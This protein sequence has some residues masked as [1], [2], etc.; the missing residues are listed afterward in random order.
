M[1]ALTEDFPPPPF[2]GF[3]PDAL[4]FFRELSAN[5]DK[6]WFVA[7]KAR[8]E[9]AVRAPLLALVGSLSQGLA[10]AGLPFRGDPKR[11]VFRLNRDV[12]FSHDKSPYKTTAGCVLTR[13][14]DKLSPGVLYFHLDPLGCFAAAGFYA[15]EPDTLHR[16]RLGILEDPKGW[17]KAISALAKTGLELSR[18]DVLIR[19]PR[20]FDAASPEI[21]DAL[22]LK[23]WVVRR[24]IPEPD[25]ASPALIETLV[26]LA[27]DAEPILRFGWRALA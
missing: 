18:G 25:L 15:P 21:S 10:A 17:A 14:G 27:Q 12:R 2:E 11:S 16:M 4:A 23:S 1:R 5:M 9:N 3:P 24:P 6:A 26:R 20:G 7:N 22:K 13:S 8:Y 19:P